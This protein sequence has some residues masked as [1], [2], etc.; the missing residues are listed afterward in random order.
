MWKINASF[1]QILMFYKHKLTVLQDMVFSVLSRD[2]GV[3]LR[4]GGLE[5]KIQSL[6]NFTTSVLKRSCFNNTFGKQVGDYS[7]PPQLRRLYSENHGKNI[8]AA[9][10]F[11]TV[12]C[13]CESGLLI[14]C[15]HG[16]IP[17]NFSRQ[18]EIPGQKSIC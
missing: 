12:D 9:I 2:G 10:F 6:G 17:D 11:A 8:Q 7:P 13:L 3:E 14:C 16:L 5:I 18:M 15:F 4:V 1:L